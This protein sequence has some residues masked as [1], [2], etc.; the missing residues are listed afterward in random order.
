MTSLPPNT[1]QPPTL[2]D[3]QRNLDTLIHSGERQA[4]SKVVQIKSEFAARGMGASTSVIGAAITQ[5]NELHETIVEQSMILIHEFSI[6]SADLSLAA[7]VQ[8][9]R[10]RLDSFA[11]MLMA[12][13]PPAG[14]PQQA[15]QSRTQYTAVFRQRLEGALKDIQI[16]F[17]GG[18]RVTPAFAAPA[19]TPGVVPA[20]QAGNLMNAVILKPT[21]MGVGIDLHKLW[22]WA[23]S[24]WRAVRGQPTRAR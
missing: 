6:G 21:F 12:T 2:F 10:T 5:F 9:A 4:R 23:E 22:L 14:F 3:F 16:G 18:R 19:A 1:F 24:K 11:T 17:I 15:Q 7:L 8:T 13:V 20:E